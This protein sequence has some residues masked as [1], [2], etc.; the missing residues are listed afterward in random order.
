MIVDLLSG[1]LGSA[2]TEITFDYMGFKLDAHMEESHDSGVS[3]TENPIEGGAVSTDHAT[4]LPKMVAVRGVV[5][6]YDPDGGGSDARMGDLYD[7]LLSLQASREKATVKTKLKTY[8][9]MIL[10]GV[11][12]SRDIE[13]KL[14][15]MLQFKEIVTV[16][17]ETVGGLVVQPPPSTAPAGRETKVDGPKKESKTAEQSAPPKSKGKTQPKPAPKEK[18]GSV[19]YGI[20]G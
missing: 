20:F 9:N 1:A 11:T 3:V 17:V 14:D 5:L 4:I 19:L 13:G 16:D 6:D 18:K 12:G 15:L 7:Q 8:E 2:Q 10:I